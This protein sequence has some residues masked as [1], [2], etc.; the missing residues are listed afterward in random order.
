[1]SHFYGQV[2]GDRGAVSRRGT[3]NSGI[4]AHVCGWDVGCRV[5]VSWDARHQCDVVEVHRTGGTN[6]S[7][8]RGQIARY[9]LP[10]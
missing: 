1:M 3:K 4:T 9:H 2:Q 10:K 6:S 8:N 7:A 5:T